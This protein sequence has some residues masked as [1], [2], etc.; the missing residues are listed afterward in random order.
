V[1]ADVVIPTWN[2]REMLVEALRAVAGEPA[3][4]IVVDNG[5]DDGTAAL[6]RAEFPDIRLLELGENAG[7]GRA[8]SLG[9]ETST[10]EAVV[11]VNN[12]VVVEPGFVSAITAP[13]ADPRVGMVAGQ[14][15]IPGT[16][17]VD[18]FGIEL[19]CALAAYN[20]ARRGTAAGRLAMPS[21]GAAAYRR[22]AFAQVGGFDARLF[23]Y[24]EDV[25]LGLRLRTAGWRAAEAPDA[26]G[27]HLGGATV[28]VNSLWQRELAG[29]A[30]GFLLRRWGV[31]ASTAAP[32]ALLMEGLVTGW[33][34]IRHRTTVPLTARVRGWRAAGPGRRRVP[35][36]AIEPGI[37]LVE[38]IR[39]LAQAR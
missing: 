38:A 36:E 11:L 20:R 10:A 3:G 22:A 13:L 15:T 4:V 33:G 12:D 18:G 29:F 25:D 8:V 21:G 14:T 39:R 32:R 27:V 23:A 7:F 31:L 1:T 17:D 5:S 37:T 34:L 30:R 28:G 19:D 35:A 16:S 24:G 9:V 26:R 6:V 2:A